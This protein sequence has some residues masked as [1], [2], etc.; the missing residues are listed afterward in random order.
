VRDYQGNPPLG[1]ISVTVQTGL[2]VSAGGAL[3]LI[4]E[5]DAWDSRISFEPGIPVDLGGALELTFAND[6]DPA[7]QVGRT[8]HVFDWTGVSP[9]GQFGVVS[10]YD[11]DT[12]QLYSTGEIT[13]LAA[14]GVIAGDANGDRTV[15]LSDFGLLKQ[16]FGAAGGRPQGDANGDGQVDLSDFGLLKLNFG[17]TAPAA[18]PEPRSLLLLAMGAA[19]VFGRQGRVFRRGRC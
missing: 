2:S 17:R 3:R 1:P 7:A 13:L 9:A 8:L 5:N 18:V 19:L 10:N 6:V 14:G 11:W 15:D 16:N 4:F 12:S